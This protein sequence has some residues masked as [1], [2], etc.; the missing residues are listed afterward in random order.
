[1]RWLTVVHS[2]VLVQSLSGGQAAGLSRGIV[3][4]YVIF[5]YLGEN[6][7]KNPSANYHWARASRHPNTETT[8]LLYP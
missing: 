4:V 5:E 6:N 1:M 3:K 8:G 7:T 2:M